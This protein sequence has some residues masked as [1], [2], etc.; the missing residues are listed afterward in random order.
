MH[1][2]DPRLIILNYVHD[3]YATAAVNRSEIRRVFNRRHTLS[4]PPMTP[5]K[6]IVRK[7]NL[8]C[9]ALKPIEIADTNAIIDS[10]RLT[11]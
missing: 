10:D 11:F 4:P 2:F 6:P 8:L 1:S 9:Y 7:Y 3:E 5:L